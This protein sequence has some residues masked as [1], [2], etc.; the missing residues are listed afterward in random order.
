MRIVSVLPRDRYLAGTAWVEADPEAGGAV[1]HGPVRARG[2]A[3]NASAAKANNVQEDP[4][5]SFG[6]H[7]Y[8]TYLV[9]E[10]VRVPPGGQ[11]RTYRPFFLRLRPVGGEAWQARL[12]GRDGLGAHGGALHTD[13]RLRETFGCLRVDDA[14]AEAWAELVTIELTA[15]RHVVYECREAKS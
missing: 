7:P 4:T 3:D 6:D 1:L 8:G 11:R 15:G 2:E 14:T 9:T 12:N 10:V 13:G 5:R